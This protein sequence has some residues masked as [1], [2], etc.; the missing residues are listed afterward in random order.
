[1]LELFVLNSLHSDL[2]VLRRDDGLV[3]NF[4]DPFTAKMSFEVRRGNDLCTPS[5]SPR[6]QR[7]MIACGSL[8]GRAAGGFRL[9]PGQG[10]S[11]CAAF[12]EQERRP[13]QTLA[14]ATPVGILPLTDA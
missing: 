3:D 13:D 8:S 2:Q 9:R 1:M 4:E 7:F 6:E 11:L 12:D 10:E 5:W 14:R